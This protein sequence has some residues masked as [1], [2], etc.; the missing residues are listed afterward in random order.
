M[1]YILSLRFDYNHS[2][3]IGVFSDYNAARQADLSFLNTYRLQSDEWTEIRKIELDKAYS[4]V[5]IFSD[6]GEKV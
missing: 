4:Y 5:D 1:I 2:Q 3:L 6:I